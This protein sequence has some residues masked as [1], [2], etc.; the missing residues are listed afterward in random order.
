[1]NKGLVIEVNGIV[2]GEYKKNYVL[3]PPVEGLLRPEVRTA[4]GVFSVS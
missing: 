1:M 4:D 3:Q 2:L